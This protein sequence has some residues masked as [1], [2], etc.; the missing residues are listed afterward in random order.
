MRRPICYCWRRA[1]G[2]VTAIAGPSQH[3]K[4]SLTSV[5]SR[6]I[7][8]A[9]SVPEAGHTRFGAS[10]SPDS[11]PLASRSWPK[12][13]QER[14]SRTRHFPP[15]R[16]KP[17]EHVSRG[18]TFEPESFQDAFDE[19]PSTLRH[20][21]RGVPRR[22][23][24]IRNK[25]YSHDFAKP[26]PVSA[27]F[28]FSFRPPNDSTGIR[29][30]SSDRN[31]PTDTYGDKTRGNTLSSFEAQDSKAQRGPK[32]KYRDTAYSMGDGN[33]P[34]KV[35]G[36]GL[37]QHRRGRTHPKYTREASEVEAQ[38]ETGQQSQF[39][40][41]GPV[42]VPAS[43]PYT[44][45]ASEFL[46]GTH[47]VK[48]ALRSGRRVLH[49]LYIY[50]G[51]HEV[52]EANQRDNSIAKLA[53]AAGVQ[54]KNVSGDWD[55]LLLKMS[56][57]RPYNGYVLEASPLPLIPALALSNVEQPSRPFS[58]VLSHQTDEEA[59]LISRITTDRLSATIPCLGKAT[60]YPFV[61]MLDQIKEPGNL[62]AIIRSAHFLG[63]DAVAVV[64]AGS[65]PF[66]AVALKASAGAAEYMPLFV[67]RKE[68]E[69]VH[70]SKKR[71]WKFF[72][73]V[74]PGSGSSRKNGP[75]V[76]ST[77]MIG[78]ALRTGPCVL[79]VGGEEEGIR[80]HLQKI[81]NYAVGIENVRDP[82]EGLDS[83]NVS[84]AAALLIQQFLT[85]GS[86]SPRQPQAEG[87]RGEDRD[88]LF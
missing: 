17:L 73:A 32:S 48:A 16:G 15:F 31:K 64:E 52:N 59:S 27:Q 57:G 84:V 26:R 22:G 20:E 28:P 54:V 76:T 3:R 71:G 47:S 41:R 12:A 81:A 79:L 53:L 24:A 29:S 69:F 77:S 40:A 45:A 70:A 78:S 4:A 23:D 63:V 46:Y 7:R 44:T 36:D 62:G 13:S 60:R 61:L 33:D 65:A 49:K 6:G 25:S 35:R 85:G 55:G 68:H 10:R 50:H 66:S 8:K 87:K 75:P 74:A 37:R 56:G 67:V 18:R 80:A 39:K 19:G 5:I 42:K 2:N 30:T 86:G 51:S 9:K 82:I 14:P 11:T 38:E 58:V 34:F 72:V 43:I 1:S 21:A 88:K 83:L